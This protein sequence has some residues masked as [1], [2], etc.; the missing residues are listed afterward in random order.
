MIYLFT[1]Y[2]YKGPYVGE[3]KAVL[4]KGYCAGQTVIDLMHD[5]PKFNPKA[6]AYLLA[7]LSKR[8]K[9]GDAC[10]AVV[11]PGVGSEHRRPVLIIADE[12]I[13]SGPDNGLFSI[14]VQ[15]AE[16]VNCYEIINGFDTTSKSFHG[17]DI[18]APALVKYLNQ[19]T[20]NFKK[21]NCMSLEG[22]NWPA[23]VNEIIYFDGFGNAIVGRHGLTVVEDNYL[24]VNGIKI[25]NAETFSAVGIHEPFWYTNSMGLVEI[26]VNQ[27]SAM[28]QLRLEIGQSVKV[29]D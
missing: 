12:V 13:Y 21:I 20:L 17:R 3:L 14:V 4:D 5:A 15:Q 18:F 25:K 1:D 19:D 2:G 24:F 7:A 26:A 10:L 29:S 22:V 27:S 11:D 6:S 16:D 8:F 9:A 23:N 28:L